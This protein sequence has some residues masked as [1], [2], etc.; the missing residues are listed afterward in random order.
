M[1]RNLSPGKGIGSSCRNHIRLWPCGASAGLL[2]VR[3]WQ[4]SSTQKMTRRSSWFG[5]RTRHG[6]WASAMCYALIATMTSWCQ[7]ASTRSKDEKKQF[8]RRCPYHCR[9]KVSY[10]A[11]ISSKRGH[12]Q[13]KQTLMFQ[14]LSAESLDIWSWIHWNQLCRIY[15][16]DNDSMMISMQHVQMYTCM[17]TYIQRKYTLISHMFTIIFTHIYIY[18]SSYAYTYTHRY[19]HPCIHTYIHTYIHRESYPPSHG[20]VGT[21]DAGNGAMYVM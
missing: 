19:I 5:Q 15:C 17:C 18:M 11:P 20:G 1:L 21:R 4:C 2:R 10:K 12:T 16:Q 6:P 13:R 14:P 9:R 3:S 8:D 7:G